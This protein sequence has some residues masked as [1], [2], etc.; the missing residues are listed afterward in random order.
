ML[1]YEFETLY[2]TP[3]Q[4]LPEVGATFRD[5]LIAERKL[6]ETEQY[7]VDKEYWLNRIESLPKAPELP[8]LRKSN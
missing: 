6:K 7:K 3:E 1:L 5:Y 2:F 8:I 4:L